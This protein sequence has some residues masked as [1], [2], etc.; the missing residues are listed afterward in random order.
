MYQSLQGNMGLGRAIQ[1]FTSWNIPVALP[2]N[3]TQKYDL[4]ADIDGK[5]QKIQVK[6]SRYMGSSLS[7]YEVQLKNSSGNKITNFDNTTCDYVFIYTADEK[8]YLIPA[9]E[10]K[11]KTAVRVGNMY[12]EYC[13]QC[14]NLSDIGD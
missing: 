1:Y 10:I 13:V 9:Q 11:A 5:L 12:K 14:K 4:I 2:L 6:T 7:S 3:D 8:I